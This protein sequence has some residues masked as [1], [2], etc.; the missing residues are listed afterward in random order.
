MY[1]PEVCG[2]RVQCAYS[3]GYLFIYFFLRP[4]VRSNTCLVCLTNLVTR[5]ISL[6]IN[7]TPTFKGTPT[8]KAQRSMLFPAAKLFYTYLHGFGSVDSESLKLRLA[9]RLWEEHGAGGVA[10]ASQRD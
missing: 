10:G 4:V 3:N 6:L 2:G 5:K 8:N 1:S 9:R 7:Q